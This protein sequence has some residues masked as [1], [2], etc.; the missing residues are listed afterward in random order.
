MARD[1][2]EMIRE[3]QDRDDPR[4]L[5]RVSQTVSKPQEVA[6]LRRA[7]KA[8][9]RLIDDL[10]Q[11]RLFPEMCESWRVRA[12]DKRISKKGGAPA[13]IADVQEANR[14]ALGIKRE[15]NGQRLARQK[16]RRDRAAAK[17][18]EPASSE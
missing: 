1:V 17:K 3:G 15:T 18:S 4:K 7:L 13:Y 14:T 8:S 9:I 5:R 10:L 11:A 2:F 16:S 12:A 6:Q